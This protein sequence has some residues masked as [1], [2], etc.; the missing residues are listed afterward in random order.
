MID[1]GLKGMRAMLGAL[2]ISF[3]SASSPYSSSSMATV[4]GSESRCGGSTGSRGCG[5]DGC[6]GGGG[7]RDGGGGVEGG[8]YSVVCGVCVWEG[9]K[10]K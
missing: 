5:S 9:G 8:K 2:M 1:G 6:G 3:S 10:M 7:G 4:M